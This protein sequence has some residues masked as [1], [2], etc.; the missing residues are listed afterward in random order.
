[1]DDW[2]LKTKTRKSQQQIQITLFRKWS[3]QKCHWTHGLDRKSQHDIDGP[4]VSV[5]ESS[6]HLSDK[7]D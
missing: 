4:C 7:G 2:N 6:Q 5:V 3:L 1:M